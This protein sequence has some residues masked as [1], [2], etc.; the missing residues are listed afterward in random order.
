MERQHTH[1]GLGVENGHKTIQNYRPTPQRHM[2]ETKNERDMPISSPAHPRRKE[3]NGGFRITLL[4]PLAA[5]A[6]GLTL[7]CSFLSPVPPPSLSLLDTCP[8]S[9]IDYLLNLLNSA[10]QATTAGVVDDSTRQKYWRHWEQH[11]RRLDIDPYLQSTSTQYKIDALQAFGARVW[12][13]DYGRRAQVVNQSFDQAWRAVGQ[14]C[15]LAGFPDPTKEAGS[16]KRLLL[17]RRQ[18]ESYTRSDPAPKPQ[19]AV[20]FSTVSCLQQERL[21]IPGDPAVAAVADLCTI[22]FY[23]LLRVG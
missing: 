10:R 3:Q 18:K 15:Q 12:K 8:P 17:L 1:S 5:P 21:I 20:P 16:D 13:G 6:R 2:P 7:L 22:A 4:H 14:T 19:L 11:A 9:E 23:F